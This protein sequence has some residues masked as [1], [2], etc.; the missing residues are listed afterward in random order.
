[1]SLLVARREE[2][3]R[4]DVTLGIEPPKRW[5][6]EVDPSATDASKKQLTNWLT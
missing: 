2:L 6:I 5:Q 4:L 1:V 3:V